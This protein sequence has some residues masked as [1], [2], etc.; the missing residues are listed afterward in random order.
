MRQYWTKFGMPFALLLQAGLVG[1]VHETV[2]V[3]APSPKAS[4]TIATPQPPEKPI[5]WL[6]PDQDG[7]K[8]APSF[9]LGSGRT[10]TIIA[11]RRV[12]RSSTAV[13]VVP[14]GT[15]TKIRQ[16][17]RIPPHLGE[18][19]AFLVGNSLYTAKDVDAPLAPVIQLP[20]ALG[21]LS[22]AGKF[23]V[24]YTSAGDR[25]GV[26]L[27]TKALVPVQPLGLLATDHGPTCYATSQGRH[28]S[29]I[30]RSI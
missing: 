2:A 15:Y 5:S 19:F 18:G 16:A 7:V 4:T 27:R 9:D 25:V 8:K 20:E 30:W 23:A 29:S 22:F 6:L 1:C 28:C 13:S 11:G 12:V 14:E 17:Y 10:G 24:L 3:K 21:S 26:D